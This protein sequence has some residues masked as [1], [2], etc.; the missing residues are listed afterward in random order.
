MLKGGLLTYRNRLYIPNCDDLKRF[1][2][3]KLH[4]KPYTGHPRYQNMI[5]GTRKKFYWLGLKKYIANY[6]AKCLE[7]QQ[8]KG[9]HRNL[10]GLLQPLPIP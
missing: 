10:A 9:E 2:M 6:L 8:V 5:I 3:D 7:S 1:I 4:K